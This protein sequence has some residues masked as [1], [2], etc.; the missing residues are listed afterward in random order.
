MAGGIVIVVILL[1]FPVLI[2]MSM[3]VLAGLIGLLVKDD[4]AAEFEG[5]EYLEL[6]Q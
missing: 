6:G 2:I 5:S 4:V 1:A 3:V